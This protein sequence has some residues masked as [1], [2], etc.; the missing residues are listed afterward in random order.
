MQI[1]RRQPTTLWYTASHANKE[2]YKNSHLI[3]PEGF[4]AFINEAS[5]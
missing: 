1:A 2:I 3:T 4:D 5:D